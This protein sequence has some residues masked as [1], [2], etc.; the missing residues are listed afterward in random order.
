MI[1]TSLVLRRREVQADMLKGN[2]DW[3]ASRAFVPYQSP[4][5]EARVQ[6]IETSGLLG[7][8][9]DWS[10]IVQVLPLNSACTTCTCQ[11]CF[12]LILFSYFCSNGFYSNIFKH[13]VTLCCSIPLVPN[14]T[15]TLS[16]FE[17]IYST[18]QNALGVYNSNA[19]SSSVPRER[20]CIKHLLG[21]WGI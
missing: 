4:T 17:W 19:A 11:L 10:T 15:F 6:L 2:V 3:L 9:L 8:I 13:A 18:D 16:S 5:Q 7:I 1:R 21:M 20:E 12:Q 14:W